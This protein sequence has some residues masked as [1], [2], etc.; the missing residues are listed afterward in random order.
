MDL[1]NLSAVSKS[2][3][4]N[5]CILCIIYDFL[6]NNNTPRAIHHISMSHKETKTSISVEK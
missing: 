1:H 4:C 3:F 6:N 5:N 2:T